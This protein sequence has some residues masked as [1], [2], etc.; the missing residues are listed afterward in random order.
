[1]PLDD[2]EEESD[3]D[4]PPRLSVALDEQESESRGSPEAARRLTLEQLRAR[5][6]RG[7]FGD[8]RLSDARFGDQE[9]LIDD[10]APDAEGTVGLDDIEMSVRYNMNDDI[11][12]DDDADVETG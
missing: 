9:E 8:V 12:D 6:S 5:S 2:V 11:D 7:S 1:M 3:E 10:G 4:A